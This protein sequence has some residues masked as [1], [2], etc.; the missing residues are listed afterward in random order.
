M[1]M[2][3]KH[4]K[5]YTNLADKAVARFGRTDFNSEIFSTKKSFVKSFVS[6][7]IENIIIV[8]NCHGHFKLQQ[9]PL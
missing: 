5:Y 1:E 4:L 6:I 9:L 7:N 2:T 8:W 3:A